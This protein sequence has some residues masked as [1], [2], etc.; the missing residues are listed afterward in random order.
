MDYISIARGAEGEVL[1]SD[2][3][4]HHFVVS[5]DVQMF[6]HFTFSSATPIVTD[7]SQ[8]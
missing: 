5:S 1:L 3:S 8:G 6:K 4:D 7:S 2:F